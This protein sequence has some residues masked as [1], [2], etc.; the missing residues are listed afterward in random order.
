M[1][2]DA[3]GLPANQGGVDLGRPFSIG[4]W[5]V[6]P[7]VD[8][9]ARD[10]QVVKLEPRKMLLLVTLARRA[11][12][13]VTPDELLDAVWPGLVVTQSS[14]YQS[15]AQLRKTMGDNRAS[16]EYIATVP[17]KGYRL[18]APVG[19]LESLEAREPAPAIAQPLPTDAKAPAGFDPASQ[20][21]RARGGPVAPTGDAAI[22]STRPAR[23]R[24]LIAAGLGVAT[25][26][27]GSAWWWRFRAPARVEGIVRIAVLPFT[28]RSEG[29]IEQA[30]ADGLANDVIHRFERSDDVLV[31]ARNSAFTLRQTTDER[32]SMRTLKQQLNADYALLGELFRTRERV[33][34]SV[35]LLLVDSGR[36]V[37]KNVFQKPVEQLAELPGLIAGGAL[38]ALG[39][40][41]AQA[42]EI[43]PLAAYEL[44][45]LG[46]NA[47]QTQRTMEGI[48][49]A[50]DYFQHAVDTDPAYARAY[51]ALASTWIAQANYGIGIGS[52]EAGA[53]AQAL[54]DKALAL[55]PNLLEGLV[56]QG[57]VHMETHW[58]EGHR[59]RAAMQKAVDLYPGNAEAQFGLGVSYAYDEQPR[60]AIKH[61]AIALE[62]DPLSY[63]IH[64]RWGQDATFAGDFEAARIHFTRAGTLM[65]KYPWRFVGPGQA[66]YAR[67]HLDDAVANYRLQF[68][69]DPRRPDAWDELAWLYLDLG[70]PVQAR[71]A[72]AR[73]ADL[74]GRNA[75]AA[76]DRAWVALA[77]G[78][79]SALSAVVNARRLED[80]VAD[81]WEVDR[82]VVEAYAGRTPT[83]KALDTLNQ[84]M[85]ADSTPW[86]GSY[87]IFLGRFTWIDLAMLYQLAGAPESGRVLLDEA[88]A[89]LTRL[90]ERGNAFHTIP[91]LEARIAALRGQPDLCMTR[92]GAAVDAGWRRTWGLPY[93]PAFRTVRDD[94]RV[95]TL[96]AR[97]KKDMD[98]QRAHVQ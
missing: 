76:I 46:L 70:M 17:R 91:Y 5:R 39:L 55:D 66:D 37:W 42:S 80:A 81:Q 15:V 63:R 19:P 90:K 94:A 14:I 58:S 69:Q 34:V 56:A 77:E 98:A 10:G 28:D 60:E 27:A 59:A 41:D 92:L 4:D 53:R 36:T 29:G 96:M 51:A 2:A 50:R 67:G 40:G 32:A 52:R 25:A 43:N 21:E 6:D 35:R 38:H 64:A 44:Y 61:Y 47:Y 24:W 84:L 16:P 74:S 72:F 89:T 48:K 1:S 82:L 3:P 9:I 73:K 18:I 54:V 68:E 75:F 79:P 93:D 13:V 26:G 85:R 57:H 97:T 31:L 22:L 78:G 33:R 86:V 23:R 83:R 87:W 8:E 7:S 88:Q 30:T 62:L 71:N 11:G 49:K 95:A 12:E 45:L 65:P 20:R